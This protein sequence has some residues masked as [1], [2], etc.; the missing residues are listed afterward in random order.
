MRAKLLWVALVAVL[1][2]PQAAS[3]GVLLYVHFGENADDFVE[4][5][6]EDDLQ[7]SYVPGAGNKIVANYYLQLTNNATIYAYRF[8]VR[9]NNKL[10]LDELVETRP[11]PMTDFID[12]SRIVPVADPNVINGINGS[13]PIGSLESLQGDGFYKL[14]TTVFSIIS[15]SSFSVQSTFAPGEV[16]VEPGQFDKVAQAGTNDLSVLDIFISDELGTFF[17]GVTG[18]SV[19]VSAIP[20]P[21]NITVFGALGLLAFAGRRRERAKNVPSAR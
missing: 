8:S 2:L 21:A 12:R 9:F 3:A 4:L 7:T 6:D 17:P 20:E 18:G 14:A 5:D 19:T 15:T 13:V 11:S 10:T 16:L 1:L